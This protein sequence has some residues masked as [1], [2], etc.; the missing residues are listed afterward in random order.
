LKNGTN[1]RIRK[2][3]QLYDSFE[4]C[5]PA[6]DRTDEY[7]FLEGPVRVCAEK[8]GQLIDAGCG[9]GYWFTVYQNWGIKKEQIL[10]LD[11]SIRAIESIRI[12]G[13]RGTHTDLT[14][15][16]ALPEDSADLCVALGSL[17]HTFDTRIAF[18]ECSR[19]VK[20][21]G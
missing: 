15:I 10:G 6:Q 7:P 3:R 9:R 19:L 11:S 12:R 2:G 16:S 4:V 8:G 5:N 13:Y 17:M 14:S 18:N 21:G 1:E 20:P